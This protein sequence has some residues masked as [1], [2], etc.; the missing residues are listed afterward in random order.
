MPGGLQSPSEMEGTSCIGGDGSGRGVWETTPLSFILLLLL[1]LEGIPVQGR[2]LAR[3]PELFVEEG[4]VAEAVILSLVVVSRIQ[5]EEGT[6]AQRGGT[7]LP[8]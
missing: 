2:M 6:R 4:V 1:T 8:V 5:R 7:G 3:C